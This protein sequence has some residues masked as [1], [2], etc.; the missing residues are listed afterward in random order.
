MSSVTCATTPARIKGSERS[1]Q[2]LA[3]LKH[4]FNPKQ[5]LEGI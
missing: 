3:V 4:L 5:D 1:E 2:Q